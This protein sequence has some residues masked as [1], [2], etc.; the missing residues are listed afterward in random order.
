RVDVYALGCVLYECLTGKVPFRANELVGLLAKI[1]LEDAPR[2]RE[3][4]PDAPEALDDLIAH[5]MAKDPAERPLDAAAVVEALRSL[6]EIKPAR[7]LRSGP[8][9]VLTGEEQRVVCI[10]LAGQPEKAA[11]ST[12]IRELLRATV[13]PFG[14]QLEPVAGGAMVVAMV[15]SG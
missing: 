2:V 15:G 13:E 5:M 12:T 6:D 9:A 11:S 1:L 8:L 4:C 7:S 3:S 14:G 10:I